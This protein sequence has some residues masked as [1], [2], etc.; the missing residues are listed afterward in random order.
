MHFTD[1][2]VEQS[3]QQYKTMH[4][5]DS[6]NNT[7]KFLFPV[8]QNASPSV[9]GNQIQK[10][11]NTLNVLRDQMMNG[12][13]EKQTNF[14]HTPICRTTHHE[15][16]AEMERSHNEL[17]SHARTG[18]QHLCFRAE[19][20]IKQLERARKMLVNA[21]RVR[22]TQQNQLSGEL[23]CIKSNTGAIF[24]PSSSM[25]FVPTII[26]QI[27]Q[28]YTNAARE[29][30]RQM[31]WLVEEIQ[32]FFFDIQADIH[33]KLMFLVNNAA[34]CEMENEEALKMALYEFSLEDR[35][36]RDGNDVSVLVEKHNVGL[37]QVTIFESNSY[38]IKHQTIVK[39]KNFSPK[40]HCDEISVIKFHSLQ[41]ELMESA[42]D[43]GAFDDASSD[44]DDDEQRDDY[45]DDRWIA[46]VDEEEDVV[47][48]QEEE[49]IHDVVV[50]YEHDAAATATPKASSSHKHNDHHHHHHHHHHHIGCVKNQLQKR[51]Q[52]KET[53]QTNSPQYIDFARTF[54]NTNQ[55]TGTLKQEERQSKQDQDLASKQMCKEFAKLERSSK[56]GGR[57]GISG[58]N[59]LER[60]NKEAATIKAM[61]KM[62]VCE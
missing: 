62:I 43:F 24:P 49:Q 12:M 60:W 8:N 61:A 16:M 41:K 1:D 45:N 47:Q 33:S 22:N 11:E 27:K 28:N 3:N 6:Y 25:W 36:K 2:K 29:L 58:K 21:K 15:R 57:H 48:P 20:A 9:V 17:R 19:E 4:N 52:F 35:R 14:S 59:V 40:T 51:V 56:T 55:T 54:Q 32:R 53:K 34:M 50:D 10:F 26:F 39:L 38:N 18:H 7:T 44:D 37:Y 30:T 13:C 23:R 31:K 42:F 5:Q 46:D